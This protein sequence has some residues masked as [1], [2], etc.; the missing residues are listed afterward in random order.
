MVNE[1]VSHKRGYRTDSPWFQAY[2]DASYIADAFDFAHAADPDCLLFYNDFGLHQKVKRQNVLNM[3][4]ELDLIESH[5][6][7]AIGWQG[8]WNLTSPTVQEIQE[9]I[10]SFASL[11]LE[12]Q[13]TELDIEVYKNPRQKE[14]PYT[15]EME[16][17]IAERYREIFEV[18]RANSDVVTDVTF[19]GVSDDKSWLNYYLNG[20]SV[21]GVTRMAYPLLFDGDHN[22]KAAYRAVA[23]F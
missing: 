10:D 19:W 1:A 9:T 14:V 13:I 3:I 12:I 20:K 23:E 15:P 8:H 11:G 7:G 5:H 17:L 22:P 4:E 2:G 6:L 21:P 18:F 16:A